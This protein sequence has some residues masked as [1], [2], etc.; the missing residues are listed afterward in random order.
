[1]MSELWSWKRLKRFSSPSARLLRHTPA[2]RGCE[3]ATS[4]AHANVATSR[5]NTRSGFVA[6]SSVGNL[7]KLWLSGSL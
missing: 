5:G 6:T 4:R 1:M 3:G 7:P 2:V